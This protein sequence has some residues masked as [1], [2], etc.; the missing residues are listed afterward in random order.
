KG[1]VGFRR[2]G[3]P[4]TEMKNQAAGTPVA[5]GQGAN[6][7]KA[8][9]NNGEQGISKNDPSAFGQQMGSNSP[10]FSSLNN[11]Q[12]GDSTSGKA[13]G[14]SANSQ[15]SSSNG[16]S[17][18]QSGNS[19]GGG[20]GTSPG[21]FGGQ[22]TGAIGGSGGA[23]SQVKNPQGQGISTAADPSNNGEE[24]YIPPTQE[25]QNDGGRTGSDIGTAPAST[26]STD[27]HE[28]GIQGRAGQNDG[29]AQT[30]E[31]RGVGVNG[32]IKTPYKEVYGEY[33]KQAGQALEGVYIPADAKDYVKEYFTQLGK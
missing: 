2:P 3:A 10:D 26:G 33:A 22:S 28:N 14:G 30:I 6:G 13:G 29:T 23:I 31:Q 11:G 4:P 1:Q 32:Q 16:S 15:N 19:A 12:S 17:D 8:E 9:T 7:S 24:V 27:S 20:T 5:D 21:T 18:G 25:P